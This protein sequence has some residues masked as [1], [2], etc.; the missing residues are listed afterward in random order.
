MCVNIILYMSRFNHAPSGDTLCRDAI[1]SKLC[2]SQNQIRSTT[3]V[4]FSS[5]TSI[6]KLKTHSQLTQSPFTGTDYLF[7]TRLNLS[8]K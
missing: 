1:S 6:V 3:F 4:F 7:A 2:T 5:F 8:V